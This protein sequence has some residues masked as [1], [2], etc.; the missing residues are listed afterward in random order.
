M[1]PLYTILILSAI[2]IQAFFTASEM[3]FTSVNR[4]KLKALLASGDPEAKEVDEFLGQEGAYLGATLMGTNIAVVVASVLATRIFAEYFSQGTVPII[5][6][7]CMV[8]ITLIFAEIV[9]KVIARQFSTDFALKAIKPLKSFHKLFF[10]LIVAVNA[11]ARTLLMPFGRRKTPW[12][13]SFTKGDLKKMLL[14]GYETGEVEADEVELI[15][16]VLEFGGKK[17]ERI[18]VPLY[19]VSSIADD[20]TTGNLKNLV[21][22]TGFSRIPVYHQNKNNIVGIVNI[23]DILFKAASGEENA[24]VN[25]FLRDPVYLKRDDGLDIALARLRHRE[26]PMGIVVEGDNRVV[27]I[28]TIED[29]LEEIVGEI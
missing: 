14:L 9:P 6:T 25:D 20:D 19:R 13:F 16:K 23:Y 17:V 21:S 28:V 26:Q 1:I 5:T 18:M 11:V 2:G 3:A 15:H 10:P 27:G 4:L 7:A 12:D 29:M 22:I 24:V 8:P